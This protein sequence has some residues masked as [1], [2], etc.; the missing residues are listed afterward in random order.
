[1][2]AQ[3]IQKAGNVEGREQYGQGV[4]WKKGKFGNVGNTK[5]EEYGRNE[6]ARR[7]QREHER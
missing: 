2:L 1:M 5:H 7:E 4:R 6:Y 3:R